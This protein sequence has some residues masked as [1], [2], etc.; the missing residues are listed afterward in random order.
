MTGSGTCHRYP[1]HHEYPRAGLDESSIHA[2]QEPAGPA[3]T[4]QSVPP[5]ASELRSFDGAVLVNT[6]ATSLSLDQQ[7]TLVSFVQDLGRGL[8]VVGGARS[9]SPGG[10]Q[11]AMNVLLYAMTH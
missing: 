2:R 3:L 5:S 8:L 11:V 7:R 4:G 1:A 9:F 10:Y 6:P